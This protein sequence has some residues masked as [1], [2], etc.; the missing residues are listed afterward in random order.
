MALAV[1]EARG[2]PKEE[3]EKSCFYHEMILICFMPLHFVVSIYT[4]KEVAVFEK[5]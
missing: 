4:N 3:K 1:F 2:T 5:L